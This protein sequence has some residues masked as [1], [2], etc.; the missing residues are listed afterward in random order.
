MHPA[1][2]VG[3]T[4]ASLIA[5]LALSS[6]AQAAYPSY[7]ASPPA[8]ACTTIT[9]ST[10]TW[11]VNVNSAAAG[12]IQCLANGSYSSTVIFKRTAADT[13]TAASVSGYG[14]V[15]AGG[16]VVQKGTG[17][18]ITLQGL[19]VENNA[20]TPPPNTAGDCLRIDAGASSSTA[21]VSVTHSLVQH[22]NRN[23]IVMARPACSG[24]TPTTGY[25]SNVTLDNDEI[26]DVGNTTTSANLVTLRGPN[27]SLTHSKLHDTPNDGVLL[28][29]AN[30]TVAHNIAFDFL[31]ADSAK[32][33]DF[34]QSWEY[35][36]D[37][38]AQGLPPINAVI[39]GNRYWH[40]T[41]PDAHFLLFA[42][43]GSGSPGA[44]R[45]ATIRS[46]EISDIG[47][48]GHAIILATSETA[49][50]VT[51]A[52][53][54]GNT[55]YDAGRVEF[56]R[57]STGTLRNNVFRLCTDNGPWVIGT[58][59][60]TIRHNTG[61]GVAG[62][63]ATGVNAANRDPLFVNPA[64]A[65]FHLQASSPEIDTGTGGGSPGGTDIDDGTRI[66]GRAVDRGSDET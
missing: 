33:P 61:S 64:A 41:G 23:G 46:N 57:G 40:A 44:F 36:T 20:V 59:A 8:H 52:L 62:C 15:L 32:H 30:N 2:C 9:S 39:E 4:L 63:T 49:G 51:G 37:D 22:C 54:D 17:G 29:G 14:A 43:G 58:G 5:G 60:V 3:T 21:P 56:N 55:F 47:T 48:G 66:V 28:W 34:I 45:D 27:S 13:V 53:V 7:P 11:Q 38:G 16:M 25:S 1:R 26:T 24:C 18:G 50:D 42:G 6:P 65:D 19:D 12:T 10:A 31:P 35:A